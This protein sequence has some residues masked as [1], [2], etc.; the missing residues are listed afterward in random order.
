MKRL[1]YL[2]RYIKLLKKN[3]DVL[4]RSRV[5]G[6]L[7]GIRYDWLYRLYTVLNLPP[8]DDENIRRYGYY[9]MDNMVKNHVAKLNEYLFQL[10][11]LEYVRIDTNN[12]IQIDQYNVKIVLR[13]KFLNLKKI[14]R[15]LIFGVPTIIIATLL[16]LFLFL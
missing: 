8:D 14:F 1:V 7:T 6:N 4:S 3:K 13:F 2:R 5:N 9:Y 12:V 11:I 16:I 15:F 10:G